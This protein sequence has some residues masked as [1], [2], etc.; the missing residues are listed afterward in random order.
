MNQMMKKT[1]LGSIIYDLRTERKYS[2]KQV[3]KGLCSEQMLAK[4]EKDE[5]DADKLLLEQIIYRLGKS[6][7]NLEI[8]LSD[9]EYEQITARDNIEQLIWKKDK[10]ELD[11]CLSEYE[12]N[13]PKNNAQLMYIKR[14]EAYI[15]MEIYKDYEKSEH[16]IKEAIQLT[17][18]GISYQNM[19]GYLISKMELENILVLA[20]IYILKE[21]IAKA[22]LW[23]DSC[24]NYINDMF[25]EGVDKAQLNSKL[26]WISSILYIKAE[27]YISAYKV[28]E[29]AINDL[30]V[31]VV[32]HFMLP[33]LEQIV[34]CC[35]MLEM[36]KKLEKWQAYY[37][38]LLEIYQK[39]GEPYYNHT[40]IFHSAYR[41]SYYL[42]SELIK[43][44][45]L[46]RNITQE[47]LI[48]GVYEF[49]E[50]LSR[51]EKGKITP[52]KK[53]LESLLDN[54][55]LDRGKYSGKIVVDNF[56]T[57]EMKEELDYFFGKG[58]FEEAKVLLDK[59]RKSVDCSKKMNRVAIE[60][61]EVMLDVEEGK[62]SYEESYSRIK[63]ILKE[64]YFEYGDQFFR[65]PFSMEMLG[66]N[67]LNILLRKMGK[68]DED[69][70]MLLNIMA[71]ADK[72]RLDNKYLSSVFSLTYMNLNQMMPEK[73]R[74]EKGI[75]YELG[76]G[77][78]SKLYVHLFEAG[79]CQEEKEAKQDMTYK[80]YL[81]SE[82]YMRRT[83]NQ[84]IIRRYYEN[85]F[86][87]S[88]PIW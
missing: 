28:C 3:S 1:V 38:A 59:M 87:E 77:N 80:A 5:V 64:T 6:M 83:K 13:M 19:T 17:L 10:Q 16:L 76:C 2:R 23:L 12:K 52:D 37:K 9:K 27:D 45:R 57:L 50:N 22:K 69:I 88:L 18:P 56:E 39:Y 21:D 54:L 72:S 58:K 81:V 20:Y 29:N 61:Y 75:S 40:S 79:V 68:K 85:E 62:Q 71:V 47:E 43:N 84:Q 73:E 4:I 67:M 70:K 32:L 7:D 53:K 25:S 33:L 42:A 60:I 86:N 65:L 48:E 15:N 35:E 30:R 51:L 14:T 46:N 66:L 34:K 36:Q 26:A 78:G 31:Y 49:P 41:M 82:L 8:I 24:R 74:C 55:D 11:K 63:N 44:E